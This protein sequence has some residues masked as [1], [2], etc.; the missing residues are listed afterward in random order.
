MRLGLLAADLAAY[1]VQ[2]GDGDLALQ[3]EAC[4]APRLL[5]SV[6]VASGVADE[7]LSGDV[8]GQRALPWS[9]RRT[10]TCTLW[11]WLPALGSLVR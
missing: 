7:E 9:R 6:L 8:V 3:R 1:R 4:R 2:V 5:R 11:N 10:T